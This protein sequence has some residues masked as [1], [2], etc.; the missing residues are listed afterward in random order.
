MPQHN[1]SRLQ[2]A[3]TVSIEAKDGVTTG[4]FRGRSCAAPSPLR[5]IGAGAARSGDAGPYLPAD[6]ARRWRAGCAPAIPKLRVDIARLA[7]LNP[8]GV[9]CE[10]MND[11]GTMARRDDLI[12]F[13]QTHGLKIATIADLIAYRRRHERIVERR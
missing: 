4:N 13:A 8:S 7:G 1:A 2:T 11:D 3:F 12:A 6:G 5:S 10:I 9:I